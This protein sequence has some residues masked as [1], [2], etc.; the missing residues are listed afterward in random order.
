MD[1]IEMIE[2]ILVFLIGLHIG[3]AIALIL[4]LLYLL[5][6]GCV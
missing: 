1:I 6:C 3:I 2:T 4:K 5:L